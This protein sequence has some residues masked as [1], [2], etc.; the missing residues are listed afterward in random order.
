MKTCLIVRLLNCLAVASIAC[1]SGCATIEEKANEDCET[2][3]VLMIGNSFSIC[4]LHEMPKIA[5]DLNL[6]LDL[7]SMYIGGCSLERHMQNVKALPPPGRCT[8]S[9]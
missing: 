5:A 1:A 4:V 2:V 9:L 7:C 8:A 3:K 6:P